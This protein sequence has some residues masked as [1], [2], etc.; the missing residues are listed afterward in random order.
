MTS[1][2]SLLYNYCFTPLF[3]IKDF[4]DY[5]KFEFI[6]LSNSNKD[7]V[8][9]DNANDFETYINSKLDNSNNFIAYGGYKEVR[10]LYKRSSHFTT[11]N[12]LDERNIHLGIDFWSK[13]GS[14]VVAPIPGKIHSF[15]N[16]TAFG[17]YGPTIILEHEID[18]TVFY[19]LYGHLSLSS[20]TNL[21]V[22]DLV[23]EGDVVGY[24]G[25]HTING[26]YAPHL[27]FQ[28]IEDIGNNF[29]DFKGV[30]SLR[31]KKE[32]FINCPDPNLLLKIYS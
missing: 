15:K 12:Y 17:D 4:T 29:G 27:H 1:F 13:V 3:V 6:D 14:S 20:I 9:I 10:N 24:L 7:L 11:E 8:S 23:N 32:D 5:E 16:N 26:N 28:I 31:D 19:T 18:S 25:D 21:K 30:T 22:G 2:E